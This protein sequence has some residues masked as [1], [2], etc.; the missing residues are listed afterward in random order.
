M[1]YMYRAAA[2][3]EI[4]ADSLRQVI[5][6]G[7]MALAELTLAMKARRSPCVIVISRI[8]IEWKSMMRF[9]SEVT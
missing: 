6:H 2:Y 9:E 1:R 3:N 7:S 5:F 8:D 4:C